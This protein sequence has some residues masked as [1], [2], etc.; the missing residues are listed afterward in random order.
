[1]GFGRVML[2]K[3]ANGLYWMC[4]YLERAETTARLVHT[5]Y[6]ISLT[7]SNNLQEQWVSVMKT[8]GMDDLFRAHNG[9]SVVD[10]S[11]NWMLRSSNNPSSVLSSISQARS[12]ARL[13]RNALTAI[14]WAA[15]NRAFID[16][17]QKLA[18]RVSE[19][20]LPEVLELIS[21]RIRSIN[22]A[23]EGTMLRNEIFNFM[24]LGTFIE[25]ADSTARII[26]VRYYVLLPS[27]NAVGSSL[28]NVQWDIILR[29]ISAKGGFRMEYGSSAGAREITEFLVLKKT[30]P[31]S[32]NFCVSKLRQNLHY[33]QTE[34]AKHTPA[35]QKA[36]QIE[37]NYMGFTT[38]ALFKFGLHEYIQKII[39][40]L[41]DL[42]SQIEADFRFHN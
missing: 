18:R 32:L 29:S 21:D 2:G 30:M 20:N 17:K 15:I 34:Q 10:N 6:R 31:R 26:D 38:E 19:R 14:V 12:N 41:I 33:L 27:L 42:S 3:T 5:A 22:G 37:E 23:I 13:V 8:A 4:R 9:N 36:I 35:F 25:R 28:D 7:R 39:A 11:I 24:R 1:M 40:S 16:I